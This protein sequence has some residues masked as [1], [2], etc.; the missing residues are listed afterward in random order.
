MIAQKAD[1]E[2]QKKNIV[3]GVLDASNKISRFG[4]FLQNLKIIIKNYTRTTVCKSIIAHERNSVYLCSLVSVFEY[5]KVP[6]SC[7]V[8]NPVRYIKM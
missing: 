1:L 2:D 4:H 3:R 8:Q 6:R 7:L 5:I